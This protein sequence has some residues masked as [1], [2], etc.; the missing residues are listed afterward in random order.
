M[1]ADRLHPGLPPGL[2]AGRSIFDND[3]TRW[4]DSKALGRGEKDLRVRLASADVFRGYDDV[5][6]ILETRDPQHDVNIRSWR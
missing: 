4:R 2:E 1:H 6:L 5:N 3:T